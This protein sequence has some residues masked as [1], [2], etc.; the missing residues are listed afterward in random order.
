M[1][2]KRM[3]EFAMECKALDDSMDFSYLNLAPSISFSNTG[4]RGEPKYFSISLTQLISVFEDI[5]AH[6]DEFEPNQHYVEGT[7]RDLFSHYLTNEIVNALS[8]VQTL[9]LFSVINKVNHIVNGI[10]EP[11]ILKTMALSPVRISNVVS[12]LKTQLPSNEEYLKS[13]SNFTGISENKI[14]YGAPGTGKSHRIEQRVN[15]NNSVRTVFHTDTQN[16]DFVGCLKPSMSERGIEYSFRPGPF[17]LALKKASLDSSKSIYL[18]I[19]EIN[20]A[21]AAAVFGETFQLLDRADNGRSQY[22][23]DITDPDMQTYLEEH[24]PNVL[25]GGRL[26]IPANLSFLATMN[27]SDQAVMPMDS[28]FKRRWQFEYVSL[29]SVEYPQGD[30]TI[31]DPTGDLIVSWESLSKTI[32]MLLSEQ[33]HIPEDRLLGP[34]FVSTNEL[35]NPIEALAGKIVMYLWED[36]L[37]HGGRDTI[38]NTDVYPTLYKLVNGIKSNEN[39]F[40]DTFISE[41]KSLLDAEVGE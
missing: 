35:A 1:F 4:R 13:I 5:N 29:E 9:P 33:E 17:C 30:F 21:T 10:E 38:F 15:N 34:W 6:F 36:V 18:V 14:Y 28:A 39:I 2:D 31:S 12:Y 27:S 26:F 37:R 32:N 16:S 41:L 3:D 24:A 20:R 25:K 22:S 23:I 11:F 40:S 7:W 19:E 8:T